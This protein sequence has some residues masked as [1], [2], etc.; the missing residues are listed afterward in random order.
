MNSI[1]EFF[2]K[3]RGAIIGALLAIIALCL[4]IYKAIIAVIIS[5]V[6]IM[7]GNVVF[8]KD[9]FKLLIKKLKSMIK[10]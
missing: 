9:D 1:K 3:Y 4:Q 7:I 2:L 5:F 6:I 8:Y 10:R